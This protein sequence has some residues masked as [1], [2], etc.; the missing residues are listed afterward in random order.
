MNKF[1]PTIYT[2]DVTK[3]DY[4]QLEVAG[5]KLLCFDLDN[6]LD[7]P[8]RMTEQLI[9][10]CI[11]AL[12][13]ISETNLEILI[14]SNNSIPERVKSFADI[15]N[16]P[17]IAQMNKPFLKNYKKSEIINQYAKEEIIFIGDKLVTDVIGGNRFGCKTVLVDPLVSNKRHWYTKIMV[18]SDTLF[19]KFIRF[20]RGNYYN[21]MESK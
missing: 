8:D 10:T 14:T 12:E 2:Q 15:I 5:I 7:I 19:Q 1:K 16:K 21:T 9:P 17:Y 4:K 20:K 11:E 13:K 3:I 18:F 6:T